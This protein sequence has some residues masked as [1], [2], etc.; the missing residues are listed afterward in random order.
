MS[1][2]MQYSLRL[3]EYQEPG[4]PLQFDWNLRQ[5]AL[6]GPSSGII[7]K[8]RHGSKQVGGSRIIK[9]KMPVGGGG[10]KV[11]GPL[12]IDRHGRINGL[13]ALGPR[14]KLNSKN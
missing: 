2:S 12:A 4:P 6:A 8:Q 13:V 5:E 3:Q 11:G 1:D 7:R 14:Q 9:V 10:H